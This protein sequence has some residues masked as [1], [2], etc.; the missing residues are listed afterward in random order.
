MMVR[1]RWRHDGSGSSLLPIGI[2][3]FGEVSLRRG[4]PGF[5]ASLL[6]PTGL[7]RRS[8]AKRE[9]AEAFLVE[10]VEDYVLQQ[11]TPAARCVLLSCTRTHRCPR[12]RLFLNRRRG[13]FVR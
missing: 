6:L 2:Q 4:K 7:Q 10:G 11:L 13:P 12:E 5:D 3:P 9:A 1:A 8:F